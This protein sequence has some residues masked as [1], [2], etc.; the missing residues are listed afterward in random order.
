[1][2]YRRTP[3]VERVF[4]GAT[5]R[6]LL[7][8]NPHDFSVGGRKSR[9]RQSDQEM[10][11]FQLATA[12]PDPTLRLFVLPE[13]YFCPAW[14]P[15]VG[16]KSNAASPFHT[17]VDAISR[18]QRPQWTTRWGKYDCHAT[19]FH[20]THE[21]LARARPQLPEGTVERFDRVVLRPVERVA[22]AG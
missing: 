3:S 22:G 18:G 10:L 5:A 14:F 17:F 11:W 15:G 4:R 16:R 9:V 7:N 13:E 20:H 12:P 1:M 8:L 2:V 19:H 6:L 21:H